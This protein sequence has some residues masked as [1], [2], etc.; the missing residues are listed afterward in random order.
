MQQR[1]QI[2][3]AARGVTVFTWWATDTIRRLKRI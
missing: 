1:L 2:A 3:A